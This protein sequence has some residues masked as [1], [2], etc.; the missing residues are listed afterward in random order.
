MATRRERVVLELEDQF[1]AGIARAAAETELLNQRVNSLSRDAVTSRRASREIAAGN[2]EVAKSAKRAESQLDKLSGR[3]RIVTE[4]AAILGPGL[5]PIGAV[6]IPAITG[7]ASALGFA[8][9]GAGVFIGAFQGVGDALKAVNKA[10]LEPTAENLEAARKAM[11]D[12]SPAAQDLVLKLRSVGPELKKL[13]DLGATG[14]FPGVVA[15]IDA[16]EDRLPDLER[17]V[18]AVSGELGD[19][20]ND[21]GVS[22]ASDRWDEFFTFLETEAPAALADTAR[23][24]GN[25]AHAA[26]EMW[27]AFAPAND[28]FMGWLVRSTG[29]L[30][31]WATKLDQTDG[32]HEFLAY[33]EKTGPQVEDT[34]GAIGN[35]AVQIV[36]A[37]APLGGPVLRGLETVADVIATI[38]DSNLGTPIFAGLAALSL[39]NRTLAVT[40]K[41]TQTTWGGKAKANVSGFLPA[42]TQ[43]TSAQDRARMSTAALAKV[44]AKRSAAIKGGLSTMGKSAGVAAGLALATSG[45]ADGIGLSNT[46]SMALMGTMGGPWGVAL[47]AGVGAVMDLTAAGDDLGESLQRLSA[48]AGNVDFTTFNRQLAD[49]KSQIDDMNNTDGFLDFFS[50]GIKQTAGQLRGD[51]KYN[52]KGDVYAPKVSDAESRQ[53][54]AGREAGAAAQLRQSAAASAAAANGYRLTGAAAREAGLSVDQLAAAVNRANQA[55]NRQGTFDAARSS[56]LDMKDALADNGTTLDR[57]TRAG[58]ANRAAMRAVAQGSLEA[59]SQIKN[60]SERAKYLDGMRDKFV[61]L[62]NAAG[63]PIPVAKRLANQLGLIDRTFKPKVQ[64]KGAKESQTRVQKL[65]AEIQAIKDKQAKVGQKGAEAARAK[66]AELR[67]QIDA[68]RDRTIHITTVRQNKG[69]SGK[70]GLG[71][72]PD[73]SAYGNIFLAVPASEEVRRYAY[74]DV[75]NRHQPELAGPG[76]VRVWR[77]EETKGEAYIP[78]ADDDRRP[79]ARAILEETAALLGGDVEWYARGGRRGGKGGRGGDGG[80]KG[81][82]HLRERL[83]DLT[84]AL[85]E[86]TKAVDA[87]TAARDALTSKRADLASG[88]TSAFTSDIFGDRSSNFAWLNPAEQNKQLTGD[89]FQTLKSDTANANAFQ[90]ILASLRSR[91]LDGDA[92]AEL[93]SKGDLQRAQEFASMSTKDLGTYES[94][95]NQRAKAASAVGQYAGMA[96]FSSLQEAQTKVLTAS[97]AEQRR[98]TRELAEVKRHLGKNPEKVGKAVAKGVNRGAAAGHRNKKGR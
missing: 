85:K 18:S 79:R 97:L 62:A 73:A 25:L 34:L 32:F 67:R 38:A 78:L 76:P 94:L 1:T 22:L 98:Q 23:A 15:G 24:T 90:Q 31:T 43:V 20:A 49:V 10:H 65:R 52:D 2:D 47:G 72:A 88:V 17:I 71:Q 4:L 48:D 55:L 93:A 54:T 26:A 27:M 77:E 33:I 68:L 82:D 14:A 91:G 70:V 74:G 39:Y 19:I 87:E 16:L 64:E 66:I 5:I 59:A 83:K 80:G 29:E 36:Q 42:L 9:L 13:R 81:K 75:A 7:I 37:T 45:L 92:L 84:A 57:N 3:V 50:D 61:K 58:L 40:G 35:M 53:V 86:S 21:A 96:A 69:A 89:P 8:A 41:L 44:E 95:Y 30:D 46:A 63:I 6:G 12:I 28:D 56:L 11:A 60:V 51:I